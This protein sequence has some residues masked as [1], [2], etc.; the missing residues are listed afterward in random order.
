ML[1]KEFMRHKISDMGSTCGK[2]LIDW[3]VVHLQGC[4]APIPGETYQMVFAVIYC[5]ASLLNTDIHRPDVEGH[6]HFALFLEKTQ[7]S[8]G[9]GW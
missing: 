9:K 8:G 6:S 3:P 2:M 5:C 4:V 1:Y 7:K